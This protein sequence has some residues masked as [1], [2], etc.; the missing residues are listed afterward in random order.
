MISQFH[1]ISYDPDINR[2]IYDKFQD[3]V[4][5]LQ[6][7]VTASEQDRTVLGERL[8]HSRGTIADLKKQLAKSSEK[9]SALSRTGEDGDLR[10]MELE[11]QLKTNKQVFNFNLILVQSD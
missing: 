5:K 1:S 8:E 10:Q 7:L 4:Q 2:L 11:A 9:I 6:K 3:K